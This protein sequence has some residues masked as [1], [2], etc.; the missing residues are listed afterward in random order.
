MNNQNI[1][2]PE[3]PD[4]SSVY[5][6][7]YY[8]LQPYI[9]MIIDQLDMQYGESAPNPEMMDRISE[10]IYNDILEMYPDI[11]EYAKQYEKKDKNEETIADVIMR[12]PRFYRRAFRRRGLLRDL[13]D[14]LFLSEFHRRRRR[15]Y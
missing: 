3:M 2:N 13:I 12:A 11:A 7:I 10:S 15:F 9:N 1:N 14:I 4:L 8:K 5:P 6:E